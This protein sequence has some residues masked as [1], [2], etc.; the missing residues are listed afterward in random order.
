MQSFEQIGVNAWEI[1]VAYMERLGTIH[2]TRGYKV[3]ECVINKWE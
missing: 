1:G 3:V 2:W